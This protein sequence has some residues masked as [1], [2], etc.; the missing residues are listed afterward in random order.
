MTNNP[1]EEHVSVHDEG[2]ASSGGPLTMMFLKIQWLEASSPSLALVDPPLP[3]IVTS[4]THQC[5]RPI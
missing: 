1:E 5:P 4:T 3:I 2:S